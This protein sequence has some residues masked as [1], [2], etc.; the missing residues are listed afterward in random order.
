MGNKTAGRG[1]VFFDRDGTLNVDKDYLH[2]IE[3]FEW[4][5]DAPQAIRWVNER[6]FLVIVV[7][8]QS[9]VA[10]GY[11][12]EEDVKRL[13]EWMNDDLKR[14]GAHIDAFYYCP[15]LPNGSVAPYAMECDCRKPKPGLV[16]RACDDFDIDRGASIMIG[17][18]SRDVECAEAAG[19]RGVLYEGGSLVALLEQELGDGRK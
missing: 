2:T 15:H 13:H 1:T 9:G 7:T 3:E 17:D 11:F 18:K 6:G 12:G 4:I 5:E 14:F 8:N 10:R 16:Q 19:L